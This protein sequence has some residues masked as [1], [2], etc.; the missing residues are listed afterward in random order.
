MK[1]TLFLATLCLGLPMV[2]TEAQAAPVQVVTLDG[3]AVGEITAA[4]EEADDADDSTAAA[5]EEDY[6][7]DAPDYEEE[8]YEEEADIVYTEEQKADALAKLKDDAEQ[9]INTVRGINSR[10]TADAAAATLNAAQ[11]TLREITPVLRSLDQ[12]EVMTIVFKTRAQMAQEIQRLTKENFYGSEALALEITG[13]ASMARPALPLTDE[14]KAEFINMDGKATPPP[15]V[16]VL[17]EGEGG[18]VRIVEQGDDEDEEDEEEE[19]NV[20]GGP[21]FTQETAWVLEASDNEKLKGRPAEDYISFIDAKL[22][23]EAIADNGYNFDNPQ[24]ETVYANGKVYCHLT[25]DLLPEKEGADRY[26]LEQWLDITAYS[27]FTSQEEAT[28]HAE[29]G[30]QLLTDSM[31]LLLTV[32]D[33]ASADAAAEQL[34]AIAAKITPKHAAAMQALS[35]EQKIALAEKNGIDPMGDAERISKVVSEK[36]YGSDKLKA[37][38]DELEEKM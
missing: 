8:D 1:N 29:E 26:V 4:D 16:V 35:T 31:K 28:K 18:S 21:G 30:M 25:A 33:K 27:V 38:M 3:E 7:E 37:A 20:S 9:S 2:G 22:N 15:P 23:L 19:L 12:D 6:D 36:F 13:N 24:L 14:L 34:S 10:E 32:K 5:A 11:K 17:E